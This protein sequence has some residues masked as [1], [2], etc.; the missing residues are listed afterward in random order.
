MV[1]QPFFWKAKNG[2]Y[3]WER[4][5]DG[6][7][8]RVFL[9]KTKRAA[10]VVWKDRLAAR[11]SSHSDASFSSVSTRW[12]EV[13]ETRKSQ[14]KITHHRLRHVKGTV[15]RF[16]A[17]HPGIRCSSIT[18][19]IAREWKS[20]ASANYEFLELAIIKQILRWATVEAKIIPSN[21]LANLRLEM[22][23]QRD[24]IVPFADHRQM[25]RGKHPSVRAFFWFLW[26]TGCRPSELARLEWTHLNADCSL[27]LL[28]KHKTS[29]KTKRPRSIFFPPNAQAILR[30]HRKDAGLV[31]RT[32]RGRFWAPG[33][34]VSCFARL[35]KEIHPL[36][37][38][39]AYSYR[40]S[41]ATR[42]LESGV[43]IADLS[44]IMGTSVRMLMKHYAHLDKSRGRLSAI[45]N[46]VRNESM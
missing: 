14:G 2:W 24:E 7:R 29:R 38:Y 17:D 35:R 6:R 27:A 34:L 10:W 20:N 8:K 41:Y 9:A 26:W 44:E 37:A 32:P 25:L 31:F 4:S 1:A 43:G 13:Q 12:L 16:K 30:R 46:Q 28:R 3:L 21:P 5:L 23:D 39:T 42:A 15:R 36:P 22:G 11:T 19:Q 33:L 45:A 40:H 18:H